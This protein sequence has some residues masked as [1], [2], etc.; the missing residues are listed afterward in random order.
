MR[1]NSLDCPKCGKLLKN[2]TRRNGF[3]LDSEWACNNPECENYDIHPFETTEKA[4]YQQRLDNVLKKFKRGDGNYLYY[5]LVLIYTLYDNQFRVTGSN[6]PISLKA[7]E[8]LLNDL[9]SDEE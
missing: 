2:Y 1:D 8:H 3:N 6:K 7:V 5:G 9:E 4:K